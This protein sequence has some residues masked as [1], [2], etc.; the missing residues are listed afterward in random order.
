MRVLRHAATLGEVVVGLLTDA[1]IASYKR[2]PYLSFEQRRE[3]I[4]SIKGV[5][6]VVPQD[7]LDYT[8]NLRNIKPDYVV[9]GDDWKDGPQARTRRKV[10]EVLQEWGGEL[11]EVAYTQGISSTQLNQ[12]R[13]TIG[14]TPDIR[15]RTLRRLIQAKPILRVLQVHDGLTGLIV[16]NA[17][18]EAGGV[19]REFDAM[20]SSSLV[21]STS[22]GKP[23]IEAVDI[24][25]RLTSINEI[26]E[27]TTKPL[28]F[29]A[30]TG[31]KQEHFAFTVKS[32]ERLG[33]SAAIIE[34]KIGLKKNSLLGSDGTQLQAEVQ[35]VCSKIRVGKHAQIT[36][37]F[38]LI[39]RVESLILGAGME[40]ALGRAQA[41]TEAGADGIMIHSC[42]KDP[43]EILEFCARWRD[44]G[45]PVPLVVVPSTY[46]QVY[47]DQLANAGVKV[48]I[49]ANHLLRAAYPAMME[50]ANSILMN[51]RAHDCEERCISIDEVLSLVP[52]TR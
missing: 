3:V 29:D 40:D 4:E 12:E 45:N 15:V 49:Y 10:I 27:V 24:T 44:V 7:T 13:K 9:H 47:E 31:G 19:P 8:E 14:T 21:D 41:Y 25:S 36:E 48:V 26:F 1:A 22:R 6:R 52:G 33:V 18:I 16:E 11:V 30:D 35:D 20:W 23:D 39:A 50:V 51:G 5:A 2:L 46:S 28:I 38:M 17:R 37:G 42:A 43:D 34:D 32:L